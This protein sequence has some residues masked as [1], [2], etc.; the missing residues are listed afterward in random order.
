MN[1]CLGAENTIK[2]YMPVIL[3][4]NK[5]NETDNVKDWLESIGYKTI[6]HRSDTVA[7]K[8]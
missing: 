5:R 3:F 4:E 1:V 7:F 6:K 2:K 8:E